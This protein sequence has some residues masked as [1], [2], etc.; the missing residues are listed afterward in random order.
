MYRDFFNNGVLPIPSAI[1][2]TGRGMHL[3][4]KLEDADKRHV[5]FY[6]NI[7]RNMCKAIN[8]WLKS[9]H[10]NYRVDFG[11]SSDVTR[12]VRVPGT[13]NQKT[14]TRCEIV[15]DFVMATEPYTLNELWGYDFA[16]HVE[17]SET[18]NN[19][20]TSYVHPSVNLNRL[21]D[22]TTLRDLRYHAH[23]DDWCR[24]RLCFLYR[25]HA[26]LA[27]YDA[28]TALEMTYKF[29]EGFK[30]KLDEKF[31]EVR[32][33]SAEEAAKKKAY[34]YKNQRLIEEL[35]ITANEIQHM[36]TILDE[37]TRKRKRNEK[38]RKTRRDK[39]GKTQKQREM[40]EARRWIK[41]LDAKGL[42]QKEIAKITG[43]SE[44]KVAR[45]RSELRSNDSEP[46]AHDNNTV[47]LQPQ[48]A[49]K[50][51]RFERIVSSK[52]TS[53]TYI[54]LTSP[55]GQLEISASPWLPSAWGDCFE[56]D[57]ADTS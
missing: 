14:G 45:L 56:E 52:S 29:N 43:F 37:V 48:T 1:T 51:L 39:D 49:N 19:K 41:A 23:K 28:D 46:K 57:M 10:Y 33:R 54:Y 24:E 18:E 17:Q 3:F 15:K 30:I 9:N 53:E 4:W 26:M 55:S 31:I 40:E 47:I 20:K 13:I 11:T 16:Q 5:K 6:R 21:K 27:G 36:E 44:S 50:T 32:T 42:T 2:S 7:V 8:A 25:Y 35:D 22:F 12:L 34:T 38:E